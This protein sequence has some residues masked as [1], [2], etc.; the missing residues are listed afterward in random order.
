MDNSP[1]GR[2]CPALP[3]AARLAGQ[4]LRNLPK[5]TQLPC[6]KV[7]NAQGKLSLALESASYKEQ[8]QRLTDEGIC[9]KNGKIALEIFGVLHT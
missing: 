1:P 9:V 5:A 4:V 7:I 3:G 8:L 2:A 6:H